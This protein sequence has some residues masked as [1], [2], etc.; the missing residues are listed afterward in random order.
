MVLKPTCDG[1]AA[2]GSDGLVAWTEAVSIEPTANKNPDQF[3]AYD[4]GSCEV[5]VSFS[6]AVEKKTMH[7]RGRTSLQTMKKSTNHEKAKQRKEFQVPILEQA[8]SRRSSRQE[9]RIGLEQDIEK[10]R[11]KLRYEEN[12]HRALERAF[13][14]PLG[15]L[16][17]L[18]PYLP[19]KTLELL[20]EVAVLEEEV[21]R[22]EEQ[23]VHLRQGL[24]EEAV[25][26][27]SSRKQI[28]PIENVEQLKAK[29]P[30]L[31]RSPS[32]GHRT[33]HESQQDKID[34]VVGGL[35]PSI[36][37][38]SPDRT[39][40]TGNLHRRQG[41]SGFE[42]KGLHFLTKATNCK[43]PLS[44]GLPETEASKPLKGLQK[45]PGPSEIGYGK[46]NQLHMTSKNTESLSQVSKART[47]AQ[48]RSSINHRA[49][50]MQPPT[51]KVQT[52]RNAVTCELGPEN[53]LRLSALEDGENMDPNKL[54]EEMVKCLLGIFL[55]LTRQSIGPEY[56]TSSVV[57]R[58]TLS[59]VSSRSFGS[60]STL[61]CKT[62]MDCSEEIDF[63]DPYGVCV[64]SGL[65]D[66]GPYKHLHDII[67]S[68]IDFSRVQ[69]SIFLLKRLKV[70]VDKLSSV[71]LRGLTHQQKLAFWINIYNVCMM[72]A[73]LEHG[74]PV[75][76]HMIVALMRKAI[77]NVGGHM[78]NA[79]TIEHF[80]LRLPYHSKDAYPK[81]GKND[82]EAAMRS[83][84]GLEWPEPLVTFALSCGSRSSPAVRVYTAAEVENELE[85]AKKEYLQAAVGVTAKK[86]L[87]VPKLLDWYLRDFAK[88]AESLLDWICLQLP[89][90]LRTAAVE[91]LE[92][93]RKELISQVIEIMPYEFDFRY[94]LAV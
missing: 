67:A 59:S 42:P 13:T 45:S 25:N 54:S 27:S 89:S 90:S 12:V 28:E 62:P 48:K 84:Y 30:E 36:S 64:E 37:E 19:P 82:K 32:W 26:I 21:V 78:L 44:K 57:S 47:T 83:V 7:T 16:P 5:P 88:D 31:L 55:K 92:R 72:H 52:E 80:I 77:L 9:K 6:H 63:R 71:D 68:S 34:F 49:A 66:I 18:P 22:L 29:K 74:I 70:L 39:S 91:C 1:F 2:L 53:M 76:P 41:S 40:Q 14:R 61:S 23:I 46:E 65:R 60:R 43:H 3:R 15:A 51:H 85:V 86:T 17:R 35:L 50:K 75:T 73:F 24:Y 20:A 81:G 11:K 56:D 87:L 79:L 38:S 93:G 10:L 33:V 8:R 69:N 58:S 4:P 94:L